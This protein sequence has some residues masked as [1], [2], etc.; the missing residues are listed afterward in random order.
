MQGWKRIRTGWCNLFRNRVCGKERGC[1]SSQTSPA[2]GHDV[3]PSSL[4]LSLSISIS[5]S[6]F[7]R[8]VNEV[9]NREKST[10][11]FP[12]RRQTSCAHSLPPLPCLLFLMLRA[13]LVIQFYPPTSIW[14]LA[15]PGEASLPGSLFLPAQPWIVLL[16]NPLSF[17]F[18]PFFLSFFHRQCCFIPPYLSSES[19]S[20]PNLQC[21]NT[22]G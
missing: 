4:S 22:Q 13:I 12:S 2:S 14:A 11:A 1:G 16:S 9:R 10:T 20:F 7:L 15:N 3:V 19:A 21:T 17:I 18:F 8:L 5:L 6:R